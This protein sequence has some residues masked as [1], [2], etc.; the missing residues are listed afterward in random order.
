MVQRVEDRGQRSEVS[1]KY[2]NDI[3]KLATKNPNHTLKA[4]RKNSGFYVFLGQSQLSFS[5]PIL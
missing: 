5:L 2:Y 3:R 4:K 1:R